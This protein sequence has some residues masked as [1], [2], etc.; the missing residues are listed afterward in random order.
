[1]SK[2]NT[3]VIFMHLLFAVVAAATAGSAAGE[4][5]QTMAIP[6]YFS[7]GSLWTQMED[8]YPTVG[9][10]VINPNSGPGASQNSDYV[11]QVASSQAAGLTVIGYVNTLSGARDFID[12]RSD[13]DAYY[14][15][16][17]TLD[18]IF[19][20]EVSTNCSDVAYYQDL[21]E[22]IKTQG[23]KGVTVIN[24]GTQTSE[25]YICVSDIIV[26]FEDNYNDEYLIYYTQPSWVTKYPRSHFWHLVYNT[27]S[28]ANMRD[29]LSLSKNRHAGWVYVTPAAGLNPWDTLPPGPYWTDELTG[30]RPPRI[31]VKVMD[32]SWNV[33]PVDF[34]ALAEKMATEENIGTVFLSISVFDLNDPQ[35]A[36]KVRSF[37]SAMHLNDIS[38]H[39]IF[40]QNKY[41]LLDFLFYT[42]SQQSSCT[43]LAFS[44]RNLPTVIGEIAAI[45]EIPCIC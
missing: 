29:A 35:Y 36:A 31:S 16:Y 40:I 24:P 37:V 45:R 32:G 14:N 2:K 8:A 25:C 1:M 9:L 42:R 39:A 4:N 43:D 27:P 3:I 17:Q 13:I 34:T 38:V 15:F 10:A 41:V 26:N 7:P 30:V 22:Y 18:G 21:Y 5:I 12:V 20:D 11:T 19:L 23:G 6:A 28:I 44:K 33:G